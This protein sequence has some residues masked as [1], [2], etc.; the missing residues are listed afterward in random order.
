[1]DVMRGLVLVNGRVFTAR[2]GEPPFDG[3]VAIVGE[4]I[5]AVGGD[6]AVRAMAPPDAL[7]VDVDG[8]TIL[9]GFI[10]PHN[11][12]AFTGA[13][14]ASVDVRY[15]GVASIARPRRAHRRGRRANPGRG[16]DPGRRRQPR[17]VP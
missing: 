13:E 12:L 15:P 5:I 17:A 4:R 2:P 1:M 16:L 8:R 14:L 7:E 3:G 10:D 9:P 11:H 6:A